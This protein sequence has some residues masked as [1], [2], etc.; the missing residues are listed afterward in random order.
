MTNCCI[1]LSAAFY[2]IRP[3]NGAGLFSKEKIS[4]GRDKYGKSEEKRMS[5]EAYDINKQTIYIIN[6]KNCSLSIVLTATDQKPQKSLK[7]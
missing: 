6:T 3:G 2:D 5:G 1:D 4:K 7:R